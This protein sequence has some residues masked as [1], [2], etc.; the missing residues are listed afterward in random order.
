MGFNQIETSKADLTVWAEPGYLLYKSQTFWPSE[1]DQTPLTEAPDLL[2]HLFVHSFTLPLDI[3]ATK[4]NSAASKLQ[5]GESKKRE[6]LL[7]LTVPFPVKGHGS[8]V[9]VRLA[10]RAC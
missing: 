4:S 7:P 6:G 2:T 10:W 9:S 1:Q 5:V 8:S 3:H